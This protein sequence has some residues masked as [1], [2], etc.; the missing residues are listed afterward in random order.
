VTTYRTV[1]V[2]AQRVITDGHTRR[3][4]IVQLPPL[5]VYDRNATT[6][7]IRARVLRY[8]ENL[9]GSRAH[10]VLNSWTVVPSD[11]RE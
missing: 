11:A 6:D 2:S 8:L 7:A 5:R 1:A 9:S 4:H 10:Y 3:V